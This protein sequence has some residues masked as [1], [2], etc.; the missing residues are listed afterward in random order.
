[1][2]AFLLGL[3]PVDMV[4]HSPD[5]IEALESLPESGG[6]EE[7]KS[8]DS[9]SKKWVSSI[10]EYAANSGSAQGSN[11]T[12]LQNN[13]GQVMYCNVPSPPPRLV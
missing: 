9:D 6:E 3:N 13:N 11:F 7:E 5:E 12:F 1:M 2:V 4:H 8:S 10:S